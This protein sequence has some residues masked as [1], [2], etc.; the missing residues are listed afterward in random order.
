MT[1]QINFNDETVALPKAKQSVAVDVKAMPQAALDHVFAYGLR[2]ILNDAMASAKTPEEAK[3]FADKRLANLMS[4][5][6][7]ASPTRTG[8]PIEDEARR[9]ARQKI[10][11][12]IRAA[13]KK[14]K[15]FDAEWFKGRVA[16]LLA[17]DPAIREAAKVA[18]EASAGLAID[19]D[20]GAL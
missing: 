16:E 5:T 9:I 2:Q 7:R 6:L 1:I 10:E 20:L 8:D 4:G 12:A 13:G 14:V 17:K 18:V 3:A 15:D 19:I 11:T